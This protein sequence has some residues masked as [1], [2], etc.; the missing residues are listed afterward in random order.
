MKFPFSKKDSHTPYEITK[1]VYTVPIS[2]YYH[3]SSRQVRY[4]LTGE[5]KE[6]PNDDRW[7]FQFWKQKTVMVPQYRRVEERSGSETRYLQ[8]G[9]V[10]DDIK[11][12][13]RIGGN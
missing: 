11:T 13:V 12:P 1:N 5:V 7:W 4:E 3:I 2:G 9:E 6:M 8:A 10:V